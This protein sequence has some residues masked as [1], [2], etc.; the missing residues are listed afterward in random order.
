MK[1]K[2]NP[3]F[4]PGVPRLTVKIILALFLGFFLICLLM[5]AVLGVSLENDVSMADLVSWCEDDYYDRDYAALYDTLTLYD[6]YGEEFAPYWE[7]VQG[8]ILQQEYIQWER[9][10][11]IGI[12]GAQEEAALRYTQ[13]Q[14]LAEQPVYPRNAKFLKELSAAA[15][16]YTAS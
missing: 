2:I 9:A 11:Q 5:A 8:S 4:V 3:N 13:L 1:I 10:A 12:D 6:L 7:I 14:T 16:A 15:E